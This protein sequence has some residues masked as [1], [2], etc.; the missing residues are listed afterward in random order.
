MWGSD[1]YFAVT[2]DSRHRGRVVAEE[3]L[4]E[5]ARHLDMVQQR[6][7]SIGL[8]LD[9]TGTALDFG[10]GV[11]RVLGAMAD[12][13]SR[14]VGVDVSRP[15]LAEAH[16]LFGDRVELRR[17]DGGDLEGCLAGLDYSFLHTVSTIQH[18]RPDHGLEVLEVLFGHLRPEGR[19]LVHLPMAAPPTLFHR[20]NA[21]RHRWPLLIRAG[22]LIAGSRRTP[23]RPSDPV[24]P[25]HLYS[26]DTVIPLFERCHMEVRLIVLDPDRMGRQ[27]AHWHLLK[28]GTPI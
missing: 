28:R 10:C 25:W 17:F 8:P 1:L 12:S 5:G 11:G 19:A 14:T 2:G 13:F 27:R 23:F 15:M 4:A 26:A 9:S 22:H 20:V 3:L 6:F 18:I 24:V 21:L 7:Q 16:R